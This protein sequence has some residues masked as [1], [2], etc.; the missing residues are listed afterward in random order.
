[1]VVRLLVI[2]PTTGKHLGI[3]VVSAYAPT[4]NASQDNKLE[5]EDSLATSICRRHFEDI[6]I[7]CADAN[8]SLG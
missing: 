6:V 3:Y 8:A 4:S 5:F 7:I 1:M 2:Y